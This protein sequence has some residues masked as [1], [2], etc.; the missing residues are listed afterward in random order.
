M[1]STFLY[2]LPVEQTEWKVEGQTTTSFTWEY[3]D[4]SADLLRLYGKGNKR[5]PP[6][7]PRYWDF[8][9]T[10]GSRYPRWLRHD[11]MRNL[12]HVWGADSLR[13]SAAVSLSASGMVQVSH[14]A[15]PEPRHVRSQI[16]PLP[17]LLFP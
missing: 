1:S 15:P 14:I 6:G 16:D 13:F 11:R 8:S 10:E 2:R 12:V 7:H 9:R 3:E 17:L 4:G 5:G